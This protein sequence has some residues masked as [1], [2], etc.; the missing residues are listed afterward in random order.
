MNRDEIETMSA[1][2][3]TDATIMLRYVL[4]LWHAP[5]ITE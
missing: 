4:K 2:E 5:W 1:G 3:Y